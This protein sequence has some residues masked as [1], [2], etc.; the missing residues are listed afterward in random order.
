MDIR[1]RHMTLAERLKIIRGETGKSQRDMAKALGI[2]TRTWQIYEEGGS[3]PGGNVLEGL[4]R[5]GFN[6][7]WVL[8][9]EGDMMRGKDLP[10]GGQGAIDREIMETTIRI[11]E[12]VFEE[13]D[14][15]LPPAKK[16]KL[17]MLLH[18][19]FVQDEQ[20]LNGAKRT[21]VELVKLAS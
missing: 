9:E 4:A 8:L 17:I 3:V 21:I 2:A 10:P 1:E 20:K 12:E 14:L 5:L 16:A 13:H 15:E 18:D 19:M 7:N 6:T 11:I